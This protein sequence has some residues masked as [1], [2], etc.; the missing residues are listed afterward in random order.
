[1]SRVRESTEGLVCQWLDDAVCIIS[2]SC[3]SKNRLS[4]GLFT[5]TMTFGFRSRCSIRRHRFLKTSTLQMPT[6]RYSMT[7]AALFRSMGLNWKFEFRSSQLVRFALLET[8]YEVR[9]HKHWSMSLTRLRLHCPCIQVTSMDQIEL[10]N[11]LL[12][13]YLKFVCKLFISLYEFIIDKIAYVK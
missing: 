4:W 10:F 1:M 2:L 5:A 7:L 9:T 12:M 3:Q 8:S 11:H 13:S 6:H